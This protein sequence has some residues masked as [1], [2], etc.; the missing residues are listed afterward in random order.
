[1]GNEETLTDDVPA[2]PADATVISISSIIL[3]ILSFTLLASLLML[4]KDLPWVS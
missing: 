1:M 4:A 2:A 3:S